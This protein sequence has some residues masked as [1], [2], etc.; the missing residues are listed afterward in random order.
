MKDLSILI[1]SYNTKGLLLQTISSLQACLSKTPDISYEVI[2]VDNGSVD[3]SIE[4]LKE[5]RIKNKELRIIEND[6]N[7]G[8]G[9]ANNIAAKKASGKYLLLLNSDTIVNSVDFKKLLSVM[10]ERKDI[11]ALTVKLNLPDGNIDPASHRGFPT[12]WRSFTYYSK[13]EKL[14]RYLPLIN[15]LFG[16]YHLTHLDLNTEHEIDSPSGAFLLT[17]KEIYDKLGGF[18]EAF[19][20]YGEDIDLAWRIK[21]SGYKIWYYPS[22]SIIHIKGQSGRKHTDKDKKSAT[23]KHFYE[24]MKIFYKKHYGQAYPGFLN[25]IVYK[26][27]D[28]KV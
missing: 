6:K 22:M 2:I 26:I 24:A 18:D 13:L 11:G 23:R 20:M 16:G 3:G 1:V 27:L 7:M 21:E 10:D 8:F 28:T 14:T 25:S 4:A 19:F 9:A 12:L 5:L 15:K 17:R